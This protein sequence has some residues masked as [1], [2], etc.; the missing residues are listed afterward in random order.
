[1]LLV[2]CTVY[3]GCQLVTESFLTPYASTGT[4]LHSYTNTRY[5]NN[6]LL[7]HGV[8]MEQ[9]ILACHPKPCSLVER[10]CHLST[11][12]VIA[13]YQREGSDTKNFC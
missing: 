8:A 12:S 11:H 9:R 3:N 5:I 7:W 6:T 13:R 2:L 10:K 4:L 1:M